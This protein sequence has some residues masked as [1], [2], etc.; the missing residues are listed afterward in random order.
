MLQDTNSLFHIGVSILCHGG[1]K[2]R[3]QGRLR[4]A[5]PWL[6]TATRRWLQSPRA[7]PEEARNTSGRSL[8]RL[9]LANYRLAGER[10]ICLSEARIHFITDRTA[11]VS[12]RSQKRWR[13]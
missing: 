7:N 12:R 10:E 1:P 9:K 4:R 3:F 11:A 5:F 2:D 8:R 6:L 13:S